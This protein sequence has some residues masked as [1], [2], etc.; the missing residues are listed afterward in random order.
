MASNILLNR[1][2]WLLDTIKRCHRI[3]RR[4]LSGRWQ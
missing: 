1:Y 3:S 2:I 4:D